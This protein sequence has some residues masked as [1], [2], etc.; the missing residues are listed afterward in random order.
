MG[1][2]KGL[3]RRRRRRLGVHTAFLAGEIRV[4]GQES[5]R[6]PGLTQQAAD[7]TLPFFLE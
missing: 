2:D 1:S 4:A 5:S 6:V 7:P 3:P